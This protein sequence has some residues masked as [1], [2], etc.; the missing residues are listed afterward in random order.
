MMSPR[1]PAALLLLTGALLGLT[2]PLGKIASLSA[3]SPIVWAWLVSF[4]AGVCLLLARLATGGRVTTNRVY[5]RYYLFSAM[6]SLVLPNLL[7]FTVIPRLGSGFT[8]ILFTLSPVITLL[9]SMLWRVRT[10]SGIGIAGIVVGFVGAVIVTSTRGEVSQPASLAW[11]AA[12]L[13]IPVSL[14]LGNIYRTRAWPDGAHPLELAIGSNLSAATVLFVLLLG[15][16]SLAD[17]QALAAVPTAAVLQVVASTAMFSL[18]FRL[19]QVGGPTYL[20]QIGYVGAA[21]ALFAGTWLLD[22]RYAWSTWAGALVIVVGIVLSVIA[23]QG[24][25]ASPAEVDPAAKGD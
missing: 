23:Q 17:L 9:L 1:S 3:V 16:G 6:V 11:L 2:F 25:G 15:Y 8:G 19:Q 4:G 24:A 14:A 13:C 12:G 5:L 18:F 21:V 20:S 10:P 7:I 22:E